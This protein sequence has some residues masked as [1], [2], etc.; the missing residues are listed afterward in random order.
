M[1]TYRSSQLRRP[2]AGVQSL[3]AFHGV[4]T[5]AEHGAA[6]AD[7]AGDRRLGSSHRRVVAQLSVHSSRG[8]DL[9][10]YMAHGGCDLFRTL[11]RKPTCSLV[12]NIMRQY[13][14]RKRSYSFAA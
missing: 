5:P 8:V 7:G 6:P 3:S 11:F 10:P 9:H 1:G 2:H 4:P 12:P 14:T 13:A